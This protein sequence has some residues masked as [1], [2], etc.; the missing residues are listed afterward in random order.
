M[1][2]FYKLLNNLQLP[3]IHRSHGKEYY[4]DPFRERLILKTP[5]ETVRQ[6]VLQYLLSYKNIPKE[7]IQV[8]MRLSKYQVNSTR[9]ADIIVERFNGNKRNNS[10]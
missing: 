2:D 7:M 1:T 6:Q 8:E 10:N 3:Q 5:E 9:R 4:V